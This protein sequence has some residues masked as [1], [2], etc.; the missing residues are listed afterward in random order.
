MGYS[1]RFEPARFVVI[2]GPKFGSAYRIGGQ[3]VLTCSHLLD[4]EGSSCNVRVDPTNVTSV[5]VEATVVWVGDG[6]GVDVALIELPESIESIGPAAFGKLPTAYNDQKVPFQ[7][8]G[9]P[10]HAGTYIQDE[11]LASGFKQVEGLIWLAD[12]SSS[13]GLLP[14]RLNP[15][16]KA[17]PISSG[18][19]PWGG[20]SGAA[21]V[22]QGL[23]LAV[24]QQH[25]RLDQANS[26]EAQPLHV[27]RNDPEWKR[28]LSK[29]GICTKFEEIRFKKK[30][31]QKGKKS[32][33]PIGPS[34][35]AASRIEP[36]SEMVA[37]LNSLNC[38]T[39]QFQF[40]TSL[41]SNPKAAAFVVQ[42]PCKP[43][44]KWLVHRLI[45]LIPN[46]EDAIHC[47]MSPESYFTGAHL[48]GRLASKLSE[49]K[50]TRISPDDESVSQYLRGGNS[51]K[52]IIIS[53][54]NLDQKMQNFEDI[55]LRDFWTPLHRLT[56]PQSPRNRA[57]R[58]ILFLT[59]ETQSGF[60]YNERVLP[61]SNL[62]CL[63]AADV[64]EWVVELN[65]PR[66]KKEQTPYQMKLVEK[67]QSFPGI[68]SSEP[69]KMLDQLC[70]H[71]GFDDGIVHVSPL[72]G[73]AS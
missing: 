15:D 12:R 32:K 10:S 62:S 55:V 19:S 73:E 38:D 25:Q 42:A 58:I 23:I 67:L 33:T 9:A 41:N 35:K 5:A 16:S 17:S 7:F 65:T 6:D 48:W 56:L 66:R 21:I 52:P 11:I 44:R 70:R 47:T 26:L 54:H 20:A 59:K 29:H 2:E 3:L 27:V 50:E 49:N 8:Y 72:W 18:K 1:P 30:S 68:E 71:V 53:I 34:D 22:C 28:L 51:L 13:P 60:N 61:L 64:E 24:Q 46:Y 37:L 40:K 39:Q 14:L 43:T 36:E 31:I 63:S 69:G 57:S 4:G 45:Q